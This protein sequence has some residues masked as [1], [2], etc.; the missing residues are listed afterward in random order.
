MSEKS[1]HASYFEITEKLDRIYNRQFEAVAAAAA[2]AQLPIM[3]EIYNPCTDFYTLPDWVQTVEESLV[4]IKELEESAYI[5]QLQQDIY[6]ALNAHLELPFDINTINYN[7]IYDNIDNIVSYVN[8]SAL[9]RGIDS[10]DV[11]GQTLSTA[12]VLEYLNEISEYPELSALL[13]GDP[14]ESEEEQE[15]RISKINEIFQAI[16][17]KLPSVFNIGKEKTII[18]LKKITDPNIAQA[19]FYWARFFKIIIEIISQ[20]F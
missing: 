8:E 15:I 14:Y 2:T 16:S 10:I 17:E 4:G 11:F 3:P 7:S 12:N 9:T 13:E 5:I 18:I 1:K 19:F 6:D 20:Y